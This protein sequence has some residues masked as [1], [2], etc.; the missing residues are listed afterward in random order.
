MVRVHASLY[1]RNSRNK[2]GD[3]KQGLGSI[4]GNISM[5]ATTTEVMLLTGITLSILFLAFY[6]TARKLRRLEEELDKKRKT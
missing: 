4:D 2:I 6:Y 3:R 5:Y 1:E